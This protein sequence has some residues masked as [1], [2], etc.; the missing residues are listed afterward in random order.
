M[1]ILSMPRWLKRSRKYNEAVR[2]LICMD[3][4]TETYNKTKEAK[5]NLHLANVAKQIDI[6]FVYFQLFLFC[7]V[8]LKSVASSQFF[9]SAYCVISRPRLEIN[10]LHRVQRS[11]FK[12]IKP[13]ERWYHH[14][15][16]S[17]LHC[18]L[19]TTFSFLQSL[20]CGIRSI[21]YFM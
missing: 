10:F 16:L 20:L 17:F 4:H 12:F 18:L 21:F 1:N 14:C 9:V 5:T 15:H 19:W 8:L 11:Q 13:L 2:L 6:S 3:K 7:V